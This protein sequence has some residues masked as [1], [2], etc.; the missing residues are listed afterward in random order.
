MQHS[1]GKRVVALL[2]AALLLCCMPGV[3][4]FAA[5][6]YT[7]GDFGDVGLGAYFIAARE[8]GSWRFLLAIDLAEGNPTTPPD[9]ALLTAHVAFMKEHAKKS[10]DAKI[11]AYASSS[12]L[13]TAIRNEYKKL[14]DIHDVLLSKRFPLDLDVAYTI[15]NSWHAPREW[16]DVERLHEGIDIICDEGTPIRAV[17]AGVI[18]RI[19]WNTLGGWRIGI[20]GDDGIYYYY[21]HMSKYARNMR[22]GAKIKRQQIIGYVGSTGYGPEGTDNIM[23]PHLHFGMYDD[24]DRSH[25]VNP[26]PFLIEWENVTRQLGR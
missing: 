5:S 22:V 9:P 10:D 3:E 24:A 11:K 6:R 14:A 21:A 16:D 19:G 1:W 7:I 13:R 18:E 4:A 17:C 2:L 15:Q 8:G 12:T 25:A 26:Y 20:R 23:I